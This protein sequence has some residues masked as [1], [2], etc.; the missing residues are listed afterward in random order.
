MKFAKEGY[1]VAA[2]PAV[3]GIVA[4]LAWSWSAGCALM[5]A[6]VLALLFFRDPER[7]PQ[8]GPGSLLAP[9]DGRVVHAGPVDKPH[10]MQAD[11]LQRVSIFMS[12]LDVHINR[13]PT[14]GVVEDLEHRAGQFR[15]AYSEEASE[16]NE[17]LSLSL[18]ASMGY[19]IVVVQIA[20]WLA[21]R[22]VCHVARGRSLARGERFGLIMFGSR[23]DVYVPDRVN[24]TVKPGDR[25]VAGTTVIGEVR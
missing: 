9:A 20:G 22:I 2:V 3:V 23:V 19:S 5:I 15:A 10:R 12:P 11:A 7:I 4:G 14:D 24:I 13:S 25:V 17:S 6:A 21:R 18:R 1:R 16:A 8:G